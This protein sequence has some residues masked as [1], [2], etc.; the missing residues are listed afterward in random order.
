MFNGKCRYNFVVH[1]E[2]IM[3]KIKGLLKEEY[4]L[5][6]VAK[7][8]DADYYNAIE[9]LCLKL[10]E[11][12]LRVKEE[13]T[14][15]ITSVYNSLCINLLSELQHFIKTRREKTIPYINGLTA[16]VAISHNCLN[17][18]KNCKEDH[19]TQIAAIEDAH[20]KIKELLNRLQK[21]ATPLYSIDTYPETYKQVRKDMVLLNQ[22]IY[23]LFYLE[24]SALIPKILEAQKNINATI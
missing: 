11:Q 9:A 21:V 10:R 8:L 1:K 17:C 16:K 15:N 23:E 19:Q 4:L 24:E 12:C 3:D 20:Y 6:N 2:I 22:M 18:G 7:H 13:D 14:Q 5:G